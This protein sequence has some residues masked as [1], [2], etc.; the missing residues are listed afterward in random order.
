MKSEAAVLVGGAVRPWDRVGD[1]VELTKPRI[2]MLVLFTVL[3]GGVIAGG[4]SRDSWVLIHAVVGTALVA[5]GATV[6]NQVFERDTDARMNR[7]ASRPIPTG[8]VSHWE[9]VVVGYGGGF[10]GT[11]Y[12]ALLVNVLSAAV[13][14]ASFLLYAFVYTPLKRVTSLNTVV[15]AVP[16][17]LPPLVGW[18][19][20]RGT[21]DIDALWLF[22]LIFF[23]QFP[24]FFAIA[25]LYR[26][27]YRGAGLRMLPTS[28]LGLLTTAWQIVSFCVLLIPVALAPVAMGS[29]GRILLFG[30]VVLGAQFLGFA[31]AF[32]LQQDQRRAR[33]VLLSSL[34]YLPFMLCLWMFDAANRGL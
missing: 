6:L 18:A 13:A 2:A 21:L 9:G 5:C 17:A 14:A 3:S 19:A 8:R 12:L 22:L 34:V 32:L 15:G 10:L 28:R 23:W 30:S 25:W 11:I 1:F 31:I 7:T 26:D 29:A 24:H 33:M 16:G 4:G 20:V 27:D